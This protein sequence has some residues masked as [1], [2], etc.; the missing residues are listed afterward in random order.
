MLLCGQASFWHQFS[1]IHQTHHKALWTIFPLINYYKN[2]GCCL[3]RFLHLTMPGTMLC[4]WYNAVQGFSEKNLHCYS[5]AITSNT[6]LRKQQT[7][8]QRQTSIF[9]AHPPSYFY[10]TLNW[11][12]KSKVHLSMQNYTFSK[13][14]WKS[15]WRNQH[16]NTLTVNSL[17][18][19]GERFSMSLK[20]D[21][22]CN[23]RN[24]TRIMNSIERVK[25]TEY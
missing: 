14:C 8:T 25:S 21:V 13:G 2:I 4:K 19:T 16:F 23:T 10:S 9:S 12:R 3:F 17:A 15:I 20:N 22:N 24:H 1:K 18:L 6:V 5:L 7:T 11:S